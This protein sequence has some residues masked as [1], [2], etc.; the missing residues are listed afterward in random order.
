MGEDEDEEDDPY[1]EPGDVIR[2]EA[3]RVRRAI[4]SRRHLLEDEDEDEEDG[5][6]GRAI[7]REAGRVRRA[8][9]MGARRR[10]LEDEDEDEAG[11]EDEAEL[12]NEE[13]VEVGRLHRRR[14][15]KKFGHGI[16]KAYDVGKKI[17]D[18]PVTKA[19]I[20]AGAAASR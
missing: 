1:W 6:V 7:R 13:E 17:Y 16:K 10:L 5:P 3:G 14:R 18:S 9:R 4:R 12:E 15:G 2:R 19:A 20:K 8:I 11:T